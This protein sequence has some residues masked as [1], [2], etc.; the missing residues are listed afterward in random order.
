MHIPGAL[1]LC[2]VSSL[3]DQSLSLPIFLA[4]STAVLLEY[5]YVEMRLVLKRRHKCR[6]ESVLQGHDRLLPYLARSYTLYRPPGI[7][8]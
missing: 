2:T 6:R 7:G 3:V 4:G 8:R 1:C 5:M